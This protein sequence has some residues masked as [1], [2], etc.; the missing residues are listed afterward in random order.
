MVQDFKK[1]KIWE[2]SVNFHK[3]LISELAKFPQEEK[4]A[5]LYNSYDF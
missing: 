2:D 3:A 4:Y 1:L 5:E